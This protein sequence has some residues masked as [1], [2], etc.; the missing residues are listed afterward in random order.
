[1]DYEAELKA[2][3]AAAGALARSTDRLNHAI[4]RTIGSTISR[5]TMAKINKMKAESEPFRRLP[6][7]EHTRIWAEIEAEETRARQLN[8]GVSRAAVEPVVAPLR[9]RLNAYVERRRRDVSLSFAAALD[10]VSADGMIMLGVLELTLAPIVDALPAADLLRRYSLALESKSAKGL[11]EARLI[12][13][14]VERGGLAKT[15]TDVPIVKQLAE[16]IADVQD[17]RCEPATELQQ[18]AEVIA[19]ASKAIS[20]ADLAQVR[21]VNPEH[22]AEPSRRMNRPSRNTWQPWR[23]QR[24]KQRQPG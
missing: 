18:I 14:R 20:R 3:R 6:S 24:Q 15:E 21:A 23:Q 4:M 7:A 10:N 11:I 8:A 1:M 13:Q 12:E 16:L 19:D 22:D 2:I 5:A 17:L 9:A